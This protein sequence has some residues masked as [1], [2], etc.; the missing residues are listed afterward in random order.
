MNSIKNEQTHAH[1]NDSL[2]Y[3]SLFITPACFN[4]NASSLG[5]SHLGPAKLGKRICSI[6][7]PTRCTF[8]CILYSSLS[9]AL[10]VL[11]AICTHPQEHKCSVQP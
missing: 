4:G 11:G 1:L 5:S 10:H 2:L 9:L 7:G 3:C 6:Q 8:L